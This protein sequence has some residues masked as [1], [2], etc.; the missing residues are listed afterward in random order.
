[1]ADG[2]RAESAPLTGMVLGRYSIGRLLGE[3]GM[4]AVYQATHQE[5]GRRVAIKTLHERFAASPEARQRFLREGRA[6]AQIRHPNVADVYD[7]AIE[8][9]CPYLVLELLE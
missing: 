7:V 1:M 6:A 5:L 9:S 2:A 3:G 4:G 8:G